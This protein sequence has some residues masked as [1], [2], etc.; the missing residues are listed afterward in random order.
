[1][2]NTDRLN[3]HRLS[4]WQTGVMEI[5][6][7]RYFVA[8]AEEGSFT[9]A[10]RR[11]HVAQQSLSEQIRALE[12]QLG[13]R[14]FDRTPRGAELTVPGKVLLR[15]ARGVLAR[16]DRAVAA[17]K[18]A[19]SGQEGELRIG[20]LA[21]VANYM[22]PPVVRAFR[23]RFPNVT[24]RTAELPIA[25][26]VEGVRTGA[27]DAGLSRP[28]LVDDLEVEEILREPVAAVLPEHHPLADR[29]L[30]TLEELS[31]EPWVLTNRSS[32]PPWHAKYDADFARAGY[33]PR[34][35]ERGTSPQNLLA[36]V[37]AG[38]GVTRLPMS[39]R[40][41]RDGGVTFVPLQDDDASVVL[42]TR[43]DASNPA[44]ST[45]RDVLNQIRRVGVPDG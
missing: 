28:P 30:L 23:E 5:R 15:E 41:L 6:Q 10:A 3:G 35:V 11:V 38:V 45:L 7:L 26:L 21:S 44:L 22:I 31:E 14:L 29:A 16:A 17:V 24:V 4:L 2:G 9:A 33:Q 25:G 37:A 32:W 13:V 8:V 34:V 12:L 27:L 42:V 1:M 36:L 43:R 40:S 18:Q 39:S 20:F 19:A